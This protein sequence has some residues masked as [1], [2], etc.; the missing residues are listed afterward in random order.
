MKVQLITR[1][2]FPVAASAAARHG[3]ENDGD[4]K[5]FPCALSDR[6]ASSLRFPCPPNMR[7]FYLSPECFKKNEDLSLFVSD[8][9]RKNDDE[10]HWA[11]IQRKRENHVFRCSEAPLWEVQSVR[12]SVSPSVCQSIR[13]SIGPYRLL[14]FDGF[15]VPRSTAWPVLALVYDARGTRSPEWELWDRAKNVMRVERIQCLIQLV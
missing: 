9:V 2:S 10:N 14:I 7:K 12:P 6:R 8:T 13:P 11:K 1:T 4:Q 15:G 3:W 5:S